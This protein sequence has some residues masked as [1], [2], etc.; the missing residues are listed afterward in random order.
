M[1]WE[2]EWEW[3]LVL[4]DTLILM[5]SEIHI[6]AMAV[7]Y[8]VIITGDIT[9]VTTEV[10]T[11]VIMA[12]TTEVFMV[13]SVPYTDIQ[14]LTISIKMY[15]MEGMRGPAQCHRDGTVM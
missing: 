1:E 6:M 7:G 3:D 14:E 4:E 15:L 11:P 13:E 9:R 8:M 5:V 12:V 10:I 2:W